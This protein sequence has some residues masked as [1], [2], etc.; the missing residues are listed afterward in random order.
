MENDELTGI[1]SIG[2]VVKSV[3]SDQEFIISQLESYITGK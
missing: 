2:D 1:V 3:I